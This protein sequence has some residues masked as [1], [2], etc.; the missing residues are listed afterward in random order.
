MVF[1][2]KEIMN[3]QE[4]W[5]DIYNRKKATDVTWFQPELKLSTKFIEN[6]NLAPSAAI[7]DVGSGASTFPDSLLKIGFFDIS[8]LDLSQ[9]ALKQ[10]KVRLGEDASRINWLIGDVTSIKFNRKYDLWHD[11]AV[12]HFLKDNESQSLYIENLK[13]SIKDGGH[14]VIATFAEDGPLKCSGLDIVRYSKDELVKK[15]EGF[16]LVEFRKETHVSPGG[17]E[18]KFNYWVFKN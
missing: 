5:N 16:E 6:L 3:N 4:H 11:R 13:N 2:R 14:I 8:V 18:Q 15:F 10:S 1:L 9:N 7:I 17:M 12:F